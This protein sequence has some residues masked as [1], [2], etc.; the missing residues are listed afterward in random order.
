MK[1]RRRRR[2]RI[3]NEYE[4]VAGDLGNNPIHASALNMTIQLAPEF[5]LFSGCQAEKDFSQSPVL[6]EN[7][8]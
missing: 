3:R 6:G 8:D 7:R 1:R 4:N 5:E 2:R